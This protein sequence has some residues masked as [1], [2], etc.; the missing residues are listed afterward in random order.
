MSSKIEMEKKSPCLRTSKIIIP[1]IQFKDKIMDRKSMK[2]IGSH[3]IVA[4]KHAK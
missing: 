4:K 2:L 1:N 3:H